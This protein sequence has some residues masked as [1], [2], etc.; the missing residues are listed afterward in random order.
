M[1]RFL[2]TKA[3]GAIDYL[4]AAMLVTGPRLLGWNPRL[5]SALDLLAGATVAY[6][7]MTDYE[8]GA[9]RVLPMPA[10]LALDGAN[11]LTTLALPGL[12][13]IEDRRITAC[14]VA[15]AAFEAAVTLSTQTEPSVNRRSPIPDGA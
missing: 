3:H 7:L 9:L 6:S 8:L 14:L 4:S 12:L 10:H 2:S 15:V 1:A 5:V 13:G 11:A